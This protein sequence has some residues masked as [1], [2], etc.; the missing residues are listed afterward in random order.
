VAAQSKL[1]KDYN[2]QLNGFIESLGWKVVTSTKEKPTIVLYPNVPVEIPPEVYGKTGKRSALVHAGEEA[3]LYYWSQFIA[4]HTCWNIGFDRGAQLLT[5]FNGGKLGTLPTDHNYSGKHLIKLYAP[6]KKLDYYQAVESSHKYGFVPP[7]NGKEKHNPYKVICEDTK[8]NIEG[9]WFKETN[10][11]SLLFDPVKDDGTT[12]KVL[13]D[14]VK[15]YVDP[16][17]EEKVDS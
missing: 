8:N 5:I 2:D 15:Y 10:S 6:D 13:K 14:V 3:Y 16:S 1:D 7:Q 11:I 17:L 4:D 12:T 9:L